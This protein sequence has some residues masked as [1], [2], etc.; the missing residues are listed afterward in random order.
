MGGAVPPPMSGNRRQQRHRTGR[1]AGLDHRD[2][3]GILRGRDWA[4][5]PAQPRMMASAARR[6]GL[7]DLGDAALGRGRVGQVSMGG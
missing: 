3:G 6:E 4:A 1:A 2:E 5:R 7:G